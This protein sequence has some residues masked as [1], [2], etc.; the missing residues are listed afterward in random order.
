M[1]DNNSNLTIE[2]LEVEKQ[3]KEIFSKITYTLDSKQYDQL[4][5]QASLYESLHALLEPFDSDDS[6][7]THVLALLNS[8]NASFFEYI[9]TIESNAIK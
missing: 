6:A 2:Q 5:R 4:S 7:L 1:T 8:L 3:V 9:E